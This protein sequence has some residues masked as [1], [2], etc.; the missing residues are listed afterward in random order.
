MVSDSSV[1][2]ETVIYEAFVCI[3]KYGGVSLHSFS[4]GKEKCREARNEKNGL[5]SNFFYFFMQAMQRN[6][7]LVLPSQQRVHK[8]SFL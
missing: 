8:L 7:T 6:L 3:G 5:V 1:S 4:G 2:A